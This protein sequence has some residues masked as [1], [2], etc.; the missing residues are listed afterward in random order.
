MRRFLIGVLIAAPAAGQ[1]APGAQLKPPVAT[2]P[3]EFNRIAAVRELAD[4]RVLIADSRDRKLMVAD[5]AFASTQQVGRGGNGPGEYQQVSRLFPLGGDSTILAGGPQPPR[6][7]L[8]SGSRVIATVPPDGK[9]FLAARDLYGVDE[10]GNALGRIMGTRPPGAASDPK[11]SHY[12]YHAV[13]ANRATGRIDTL[14]HLSGETYAV[15]QV[16]TTARP[17]WNFTQL[18]FSA[19]EQMLLFPDGWI[20]VVRVEPYR[21]EWRN[22]AGTWIRG[23]TL[24]SQQVRADQ[25]ELDAWLVRYNRTAPTP[26]KSIGVHAETIVPIRNGLLMVGPGGQVVISRTPWSGAPDN[27][28]DFVD[29]RGQI[30]TTLRLPF[31]E[32]M[33]GFGRNA[34]YVAVTDDDGV[35]RLRKHPWP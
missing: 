28:Y 22:P 9:V 23:P 14:F 18:E 11:R 24:L 29:R 6:W 26:K 20:A 25:K 19:P 27:N 30:A 17:F 1:G 8:L 13:L 34:A 32:R 31:N 33:V 16:G 4:G 21:V 12:Y 35:E 2:L 5:A 10:R 3:V 15:E 7:I